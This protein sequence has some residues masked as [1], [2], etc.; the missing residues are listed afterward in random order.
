MLVNCI[1]A[2]N[3]VSHSIDSINA[4]SEG[5]G[6]VSCMTD[7]LVAICFH[8]PSGMADV[9]SFQMEVLNSLFLSTILHGWWGRCC[10]PFFS[11][12]RQVAPIV[13]RHEYLIHCWGL[14]ARKKCSDF[15]FYSTIS[16][17]SNHISHCCIII[18]FFENLLI[19]F[20]FFLVIQSASKNTAS[21]QGISLPLLIISIKL[22][23]F[24]NSI[25]LTNFLE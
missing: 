22:L 18:E 7:G 11:C 12:H 21:N 6:V 10:E 1:Y 25:S 23:W 16:A 13:I 4:R 8:E 20:N 17:R 9:V 19:K 3:I 15:W 5:F 24:S 14:V 2:F